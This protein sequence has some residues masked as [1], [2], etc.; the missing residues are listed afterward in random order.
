MP[1]TAPMPRLP[2]PCL[3]CGT[4]VELE[5]CPACGQRRG[6]H[7]RSVWSLV[8]DFFRETLELDGR[9]GRTLRAMLRPGR[10]TREYNEGKRQRY[11]SP[12]RLYLFIS[13][14]LF[15][16]ASI[17][18]RIHMMLD[19]S[20]PTEELRI[21][22]PDTAGIPTDNAAG[23]AIQE[24]LDELRRMPPAEREEEI[25]TSALDHGPMVM[26]FMLPVFA[27]WLK[28]VFVGTGRLLVEHLV[29]SLHLHSVWFLLLLPA[30]INAAAWSAIFVLPIPVYTFV[31][32][33]TA[34]DAGWGA[35]LLRFLVLGVTY[36]TCLAIGFASAFL[37]AVLVG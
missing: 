7:R 29:F 36:G 15:A 13:V 21:D 18:L 26:F 22:D 8:G 11:V 9:L 25:V 3:N 2:E 14:V 16:S 32:L 35:T 30:V 12:V 24:R 5:F 27:V 33:R 28:I 31:A 6:D 23:R 19:P 10:I 17:S 34:Y 4:A 20:P 1:D 37:L